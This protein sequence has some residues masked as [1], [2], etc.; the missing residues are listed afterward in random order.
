MKLKLRPGTYHCGT[1]DGTYL[2]TPRGPIS[3]PGSQLHRWIDRLAAHL[4][5][6]R[7]LADLT[8]N[9]PADRKTALHKV[10]T[11]LLDLG[12]IMETSDPPAPAWAE[13]SALVLGSGALAEAVREAVRIL[14]LKCPEGLLW[15][16]G[17][18]EGVLQGIAPGDL[19]F[20]LSRD[21]D[22][23]RACRLEHTCGTAG[24]VLFPALLFGNAVFLGPTGGMSAALRRFT[25]PSTQDKA[26]LTDLA[27][28]VIANQLVH[29]AFTEL[30]GGEP[31][32]TVVTRV[33]LRT[34]RTTVH[35]FQVDERARDFSERANS[36]SDDLFGRFGRIDEGD[37]AQFPLHVA[38]TV[39]PGVGPVY[40]Y[41]VDFATARHRTALRA[42]AASVSLTH[43]RPLPI[44]GPGVGPV[45]DL[46]RIELD[47]TG[48]RYRCLAV[49][50]PEP[51]RCV[52]LTCRLGVPAV[53]TE[54]GGRTVAHT[55]GGT[56]A[57]AVRDGLEQALL[58]FQ[59]R[60]NDQPEYAPPPVPQL[61]TQGVVRDA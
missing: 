6:S 8:A 10:I 16:T 60:V 20:D 3:L 41:G 49:A 57:D 59:A 46:D 29:R 25:P 58:A 38:R 61:P 39:V 14:G 12:V 32:S 30:P 42:L 4:D 19:V 51:V 18:P 48:A 33:D 1:P 13:R 2:L 24:A 5:G 50:L 28:R 21:P 53:A 17:C 9:L 15:D 54:I 37:L 56:L 52:D 35:R 26:P 45:I 34:L 40:G 23:A 47:P 22:P 7:T 36:M 44:D 55:A 27:A 11:T 43:C 31:P